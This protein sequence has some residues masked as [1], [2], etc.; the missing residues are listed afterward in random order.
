MPR[1]RP[2]SCEH[3]G[4]MQLKRDQVC[5]NCGEMTARAKRLWRFDLFRY[6]FMALAFVGLYFYLRSLAS[7]PI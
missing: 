2:I 6:A 7:A 5:E 4:F 3:C 1:H